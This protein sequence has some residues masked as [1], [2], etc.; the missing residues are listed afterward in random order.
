MNTPEINPSI[1]NIS[2]IMLPEKD[3]SQEKYGHFEVN[4]EEIKK[5]S[6]VCSILINQ[7][8]ELPMRITKVKYSTIQ[9]FPEQLELL[10]Y[11]HNTMEVIEFSP[12]RVY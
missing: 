1:I 8:F 5:Q 12:S 2:P 7:K 9:A 4:D 10:C 6:K 11:R 3:Y